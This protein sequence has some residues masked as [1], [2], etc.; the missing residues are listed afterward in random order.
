M[1][2]GVRRPH[3]EYELTDAAAALFP[4][5]YEPVLRALVDVLGERVS[6]EE[7]Q[8]MLLEAGR[9]LLGP[10]VGDIGE[11]E[12]AAWFRAALARLGGA[13]TGFEVVDQAAGGE[14]AVVRTCACPLADVT[15]AHPEL[16][17]LVAQVLSEL[18]GMEVRE[19]CV[20][21]G[22][23]RCAFE[24][25]RADGGDRAGPGAPSAGTNEPER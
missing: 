2:P 17:P 7:R 9:R 15:R 6:A 5:V 10:R 19:Q 3:V 25:R 20:R 12:P 14:Q 8:Q 21:E 18:S 11:R 24:V 13:A 22:A 1:R 4:K 16:C 23:P